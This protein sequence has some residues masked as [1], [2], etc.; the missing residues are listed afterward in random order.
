[1]DISVPDFLYLVGL[2]GLLYKI[3]PA[4]CSQTSEN[5]VAHVN[6]S[7]ISGH[8]PAPSAVAFGEDVKISSITFCGNY[9]KAGMRRMAI[10]PQDFYTKQC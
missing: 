3:V 7:Q 1:M 8:K 6:N 5:Y 4:A 2:G 10:Q 9:R